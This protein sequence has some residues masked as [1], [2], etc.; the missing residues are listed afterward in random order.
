MSSSHGSFAEGLPTEQAEVDAIAPVHSFYELQAVRPGA[1]PYHLP[2][3]SQTL[4]IGS[5]A[6]EAFPNGTEW[7]V[8][9]E[10]EEVFL[11][12]SRGQR[13]PLV[14]GQSL[15]L[16]G[17]RL[18]LVDLRRPP[19][20]YLHGVSEAVVGRVWPLLE[21][22]T[23]VGRKGKRINPI[24]LSDATVSRTHATFLPAPA[25]SIELLNESSAPT[26]VNG[27][28]MNSGAR[29]VLSQG[30]LLTFGSSLFRFRLAVTSNSLD[31]RLDLK[32]LGTFALEL[33]GEPMPWQVTNPKAQWLLG[34]LGTRWGEP[35]S[36]EW[37]IGN[38]WPEAST[39]RARKNLGYALKQIRET[40]GLSEEAF[41]SLVLRTTSSLSLNP[42]RLGSH[43]FIEVRGASGGS[44]G[45]TSA[46]SLERLCALY[47]GEFL[48]G[49]YDE[50]A[51]VER[52]KLSRDFLNALLRA[53]EHFRATR[54]LESVKLAAAKIREIDP[55]EQQATRILMETAL[56]AARPELA[57]EA[58]RTLEKSLAR[59][60]LEP[61][62]EL[63]K[64][65]Y[66][67]ELGL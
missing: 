16:E 61:D 34:L 37:I 63:L 58:Y 21:Q 24:E 57:L 35:V 8:R 4:E 25:G 50:W 47:Q 22:Q 20:A 9:L 64:L 49:C 48:P 19:L 42:K 28:P 67:A 52:G 39:S 59:E 36:V 5:L 65:R 38:F 15:E 26:L 14:V 27:A 2:F 13:R 43:D 40:L 54:E 31:A 23:C 66:R 32:T 29:I 18:T 62:T 41:D 60:E 7:S 3:F 33:G 10:G 44:A 51:E 6:P 12:D 46:A 1:T 17:V 53:G 56:E 45:L 11:A 30:D 55:T